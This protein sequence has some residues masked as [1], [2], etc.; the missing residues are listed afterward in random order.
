M[1]TLM[2]I[3]LAA[4]FSL[5]V[6]AASSKVEVKNATVTEPKATDVL[7]ERLFERPGIRPDGSVY[8]PRGRNGCRPEVG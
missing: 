1:K 6:M 4:L 3:T 2:T 8:C 5:P 7:A